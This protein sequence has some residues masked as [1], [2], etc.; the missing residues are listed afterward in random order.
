MYKFTLLYAKKMTKT[1]EKPY[2]Q[3][4]RTTGQLNVILEY[5]EIIAPRNGT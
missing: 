3:D 2:P 1:I 5:I 4:N